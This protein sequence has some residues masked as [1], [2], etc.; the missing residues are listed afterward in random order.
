MGLTWAAGWMP[1]GALFGLALAVFN[2]NP[3]G[4]L[5]EW[6]WTLAKIFGTLGF[7]GGSIFSAVLRLAEGSRQFDELSLPRVATWGGVGGLLLG[8]FG[9][10]LNGGLNLMAF[11]VVVVSVTTLLGVASA[12]GTLALARRAEG[13][14]LLTASS[15][16]EEVGL[17]EQETKHLLG[18]G[19]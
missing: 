13:E 8:G 1:I 12:V 11:D 2:L 9:L 18:D 3:A 6:A 5:F 16:I 17:T 19:G 4:G 14:P 10:A 15:D 7:F